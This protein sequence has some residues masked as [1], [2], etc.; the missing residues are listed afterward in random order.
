[1]WIEGHGQQIPIVEIITFLKES[2][3]KM[4]V[5]QIEESV[6]NIKNFAYKSTKLINIL[7]T[8]VQEHV[9]LMTIAAAE[10]KDKQIQ[11]LAYH[12]ISILH[13]IRLHHQKHRT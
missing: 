7:L 12:L 5:N 2:Y 13:G 8:T 6:T 4:T 9:D 3:S 10:L 1:M 11:D